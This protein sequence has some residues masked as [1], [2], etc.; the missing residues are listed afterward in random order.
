M[1]Q[2][3]KALMRYRART[4]MGVSDFPLLQTIHITLIQY[5]HHRASPLH[6]PPYMIHRILL[7]LCK[8]TLQYMSNANPAPAGESYFHSAHFSVSALKMCL[9]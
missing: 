2:T 9:K 1:P 5:P 6:D 8:N 3:P 7:A 4:Q